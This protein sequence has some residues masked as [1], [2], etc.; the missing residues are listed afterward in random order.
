MTELF[1]IPSCSFAPT[2]ATRVRYSMYTDT[3]VPPD[4]PRAENPPDVIRCLT[5]DDG[6]GG[7]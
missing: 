1:D 4:E 5:D 6:D 2:T 7:V 3:P